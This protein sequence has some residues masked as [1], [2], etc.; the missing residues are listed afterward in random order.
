VATRVCLTG[1]V[2]VKSTV[3]RRSLTSFS[4]HDLKCRELHLSAAYILP[5]CQAE[6]VTQCC[7]FFAL[8]F[9]TSSKLLF[10]WSDLLDLMAAIMMI[11]MIWFLCIYCVAC[12]SF[13][14]VC[15]SSFWRLQRCFSCVMLYV[16]SWCNQI[17]PSPS[18]LLFITVHA[19][20]V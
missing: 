8:I 5:W 4:C 10:I 14:Y 9:N 3:W 15:E 13:L 12:I 17:P 11:L 18:L 7:F 2:A 20:S 19:Y 6:G 1:V 16:T